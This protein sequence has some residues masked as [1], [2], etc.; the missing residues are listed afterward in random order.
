MAAEVAAALDDGQSVQATS[1]ATRGSTG[2]DTSSLAAQIIT[3]SNS[4]DPTRSSSTCD[5]RRLSR[6]DEVLQAD[7]GRVE[8]RRGPA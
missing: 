1:F 5:A 7:A 4:P 3:A 6:E 8:A 2:D